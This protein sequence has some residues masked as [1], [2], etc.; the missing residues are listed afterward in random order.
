MHGLGPGLFGISKVNLGAG[1]VRLGEQVP[2]VSL[3]TND[4]LGS[5]LVVLGVF[6]SRRCSIK[7]QIVTIPN[8][9]R[10]EEE[11]CH[12]LEIANVF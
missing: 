5:R 4:S 10:D 2:G 8:V 3:V 7:V 9:P 12:S 6:L 11:D 1:V